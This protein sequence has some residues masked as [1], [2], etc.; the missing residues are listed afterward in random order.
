MNLKAG[1]LNVE[2]MNEYD[3]WYSINKVYVM[4]LKYI[5]FYTTYY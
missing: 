1:I 2:I 3:Q 4:E 5:T